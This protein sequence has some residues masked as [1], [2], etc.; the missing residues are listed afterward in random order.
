M[1]SSISE[2]QKYRKMETS[3]KFIIESLL[4]VSEKPLGMDQFA[5]ILPDY[6]TKDIKNSLKELS[7]EYEK[8]NGAFGLYEVAGG[9]QLRTKPIYSEWIR[10]LLKP[11][12][13]RLTRAAMETLAIIA[14]KQ[15]ITKSEID[16]I[17]GVDSGGIVRFLIER[18][19]ARITGR[20]DIPGKPMMYGTSGYF[21]EL[22]GLKSLKDL[23]LTHELGS[24]SPQ[25][26]T[27]PESHGRKESINELFDSVISKSDS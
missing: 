20:K 25:E 3:L 22:F 10:K 18:K 2:K 27:L 14:Y 13:S 23:P 19:L 24:T 5:D 7:E 6:D 4:F 16:H 8:R 21:L 17:R 15:P 11:P 26:E 9:F 1:G 12:K